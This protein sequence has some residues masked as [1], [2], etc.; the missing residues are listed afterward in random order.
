[1]TR[2]R[3]YFLVF[4]FLGILAG[5]V[6]IF[7]WVSQ[8]SESIKPGMT[9]KQM[10]DVLGPSNTLPDEIAQIVIDWIY[11][12][13]PRDLPGIHSPRK[14]AKT[15]YSG[16][17]FLIIVEFNAEDTAISVHQ[18]RMGLEETFLDKVRRRLGL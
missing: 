6:F 1:M 10:E 8:T 3:R 2:R 17:G 15:W 9:L 5:G 12:D 18:G 14:Y 13:K 11:T 7:F 16:D 4:G